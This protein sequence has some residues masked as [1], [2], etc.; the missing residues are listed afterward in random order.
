MDRKLLRSVLAEMDAGKAALTRKQV[1]PD[2]APKKRRA[3]KPKEELSPEQL[4]DAKQK[5]E[6]RMQ[7][8]SEGE[9]EIPDVDADVDADVDLDVIIDD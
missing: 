1:Q 4:E 2:T 3:R 9:P 8:G 6:E 7:D 5:L